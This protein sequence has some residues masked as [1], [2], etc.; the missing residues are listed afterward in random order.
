MTNEQAL[1]VDWKAMS[2]DAGR[3]MSFGARLW[4][5]AIGI[6]ALFAPGT[7]LVVLMRII[8]KVIIQETDDAEQIAL[9]VKALGAE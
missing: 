3:R 6:I 9:F 1:H 4:F 2:S 5:F 7:C 8:S